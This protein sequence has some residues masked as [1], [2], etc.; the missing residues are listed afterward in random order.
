VRDIV[1]DGLA[2]RSSSRIYGRSRRRR[3]RGVRN[4][5]EWLQCDRTWK[6]ADLW[7]EDAMRI[8]RAHAARARSLM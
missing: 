1:L 8:S 3:K 2:D 7:W 5:R 6:S 4:S